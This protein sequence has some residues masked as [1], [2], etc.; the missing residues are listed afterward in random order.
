MV[1]VDAGPCDCCLPGSSGS[2]GHAGLTTTCQFSC[3][4]TPIAVP[5]FLTLTY[6][7]GGVCSCL[8][9]SGTPQV[10]QSDGVTAWNF[11]LTCSPTLKAIFQFRCGFAANTFTLQAAFVDQFGTTL[12]NIGSPG[13]NSTTGTC[14]PFY[15]NFGNLS[16]IPG[17]GSV[18][19]G[20]TAGSA[21]YRVE[22]S[23]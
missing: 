19:I 2:S 14:S 18:C 1:V 20:C 5:L 11:T 13:G 4:T 23:E 6:V 21:V 9:A 22:I 10:V 17:S 12:C 15:V 8:A 3:G 7:S 16:I